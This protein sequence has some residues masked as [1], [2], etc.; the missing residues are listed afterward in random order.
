MTVSFHNSEQKLITIGNFEIP[1][2]SCRESSNS[3]EFPPGIPPGILRQADSWEFQGIRERG[4][5]AAVVRVMT[6]HP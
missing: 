1:R 4:F 2:H 5:P 6:C 3:R